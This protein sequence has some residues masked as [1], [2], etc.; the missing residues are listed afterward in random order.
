MIDSFPNERRMHCET[1]ALVNTMEYYGWNISESMAFGI[2][3]GLYFLYFPWVKVNDSEM[4]V[5]RTR[6]L[7][8]IRRFSKRMHL[9]YHEESFGSNREKAQKALDELVAKNIPVGLV[10]NV[11][12]MRFLNDVGM[13]SNFNGHNMT[14]I[15]KEGDQ[16]IIADTDQKLPNDDYVRLD[17]VR[18]KHSRFRS[19][20]GAPHGR[21]YYFD[22]MP[23]GFSG[24]LDL[25]S[26]IIG[27]LKE[28]CKNMLGIPFPFFGCKGIRFCAKDMRKWEDKYS[29]KQIKDKLYWYYTLLE[30]GGTGGAGYRFIFADFLKEAAEL[31]NDD[32]LLKCSEYIVKAADCWRYF[33]LGI[34]RNIKGSGYG[35]REIADFVDEAAE[36]EK[37]TFLTIK[38]D[39]LKNK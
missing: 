19:G 2:G 15:G 9:G 5:M 7:Y 24:Q 1:G 18:L 32:S 34:T 26:G 4:L 29:P 13:T 27:G 14:V 37:K 17:E 31:F 23:E 16:Y 28:T 25:K 21:M 38:N 33:T 10:V 36:Y 6:P 20:L 22:A 39:F 35:I 3:S 30:Q 8:I 12:D 11:M